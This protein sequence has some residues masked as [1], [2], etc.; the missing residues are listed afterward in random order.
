MNMS[1]DEDAITSCQRGDIEGL[2]ALI[3]RHQADALRLAYLLTGDRYLAEDIVQ[4]SFLH[5]YAAMPR[6]RAGHPFRPWFHQIVTNTTRMHLRSAAR[7]RETSI[8]GLAGDAVQEAT[9]WSDSARA[10][11]NPAAHAERMEDRAAI[12]QALALLTRKQREAVA[13]RYYFAYRD[14][15]IAAILG[16]R[17][18][19][20]RHRVYDGLRALQQVI[21]SRFPW[22]LQESASAPYG[23]HSALTTTAKEQDIN[24]TVR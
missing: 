19:T 9:G 23:Q 20:A 2:A 16:C 15:E 24:E 10:D 13:L 8:T 22:L 3:R 17:V 6:F 18:N 4:E 14:E 21:Q 7:R 5:A 12:G 11:A 1:S